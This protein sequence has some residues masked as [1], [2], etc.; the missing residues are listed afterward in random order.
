MNPASAPAG[1]SAPGLKLDSRANIWNW[2]QRLTAAEIARVRA[3]TETLA[4]HFYD[5][6]DWDV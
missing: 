6:A 4:G 2:R 3:R 5:A 1:E